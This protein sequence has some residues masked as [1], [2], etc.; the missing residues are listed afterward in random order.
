MEGKGK[1]SICGGDTSK[2]DLESVMGLPVCSSCRDDMGLGQISPEESD[3]RLNDLLEK[4]GQRILPL[5]T[6]LMGS[7]SREVGWKLLAMAPFI[8]EQVEEGSRKALM[9]SALILMGSSIIRLGKGQPGELSE[10]EASLFLVLGQYLD[11]S[12]MGKITADLGLKENNKLHDMILAEDHDHIL[13]G[14]LR[15]LDHGED[16]EKMTTI[17]RAMRLLRHGS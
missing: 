15:D 1:C 4:R 17:L 11:L 2:D 6:P 16:P 5:A 9:E 14:L 13:F 8:G 10:K 7:K 3:P 12:I